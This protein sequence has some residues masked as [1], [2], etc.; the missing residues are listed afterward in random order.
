M[1]RKE[2]PIPLERDFPSSSL[3]AQWN[4]RLPFADNLISVLNQEFPTGYLADLKKEE[5]IFITNY[6]VIN[7]P[8]ANEEARVAAMI[9]VPSSHDSGKSLSFQVHFLAQERRSRTD[10]RRAESEAVTARVQKFVSQLIR[11]LAEGQ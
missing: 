1:G 4:K 5:R 7:D 9:K 10:W 3:S 8:A 2:T 11:E 6:K